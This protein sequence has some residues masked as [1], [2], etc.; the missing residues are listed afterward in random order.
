MNLLLTFDSE[1][2]TRFFLPVRLN[3]ARYTDFFGK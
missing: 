3:T 2:K 1:F